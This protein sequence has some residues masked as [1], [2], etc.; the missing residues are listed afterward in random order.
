[1]KKFLSIIGV[2]CLLFSFTAS[3][4][5]DPSGMK[6]VFTKTSEEVTVD[7]YVCGG[8]EELE[9]ARTFIKYNPATLKID[10]TEPYKNHA[11]ALENSAVPE[12][13]YADVYKLNVGD[14]THRF[15][16]DT[17]N[18]YYQYGYTVN[19]EK[20]AYK[21]TSDDNEYKFATINFDIFDTTNFVQ[22]DISVVKQ[23]PMSKQNAQG[24]SKIIANNTL[25]NDNLTI[26][27][28]Y[29]GFE[30]DPT[31]TVASDSVN[32]ATEGGIVDI[33][34][35]AKGEAYTVTAV[36]PI[37]KVATIYINGAA[38]PGKGIY[39]GTF[40]EDTTVK[41]EYNDVVAED[42]ILTWIIPMDVVYGTDN[43]IAAFGKGTIGEKDFG[44]E[45][46]GGAFE[47]AKKYSAE[48][49]TFGDNVFAVEIK[50][51]PASEDKYHARA[52]IG[53][54]YGNKVDF[55]K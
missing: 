5:K 50:D 46:S 15:L 13:E 40:T 36:A 55:T 48:G 39:T 35:P 10:D 34:T 42:S 41:V 12:N 8:F 9:Q 3:A 43:G 49:Q 25:T 18:K 27:S 26:T 1:M 19:A 20:P 54:A 16:A 33:T 7:I 4:A 24:Q 2:M 14:F 29:I 23:V 38:I 11:K 52:Y 37:G 53:D 21:F 51:A 45:F 32:T 6:C 22:D 31:F 17:T 44:I 28:N 30:T 47:A